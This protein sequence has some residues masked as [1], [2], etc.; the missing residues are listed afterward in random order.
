MLGQTSIEPHLEGFDE[1][2]R[3]NVGCRS[4]EN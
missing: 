4:S 1:G 3:V 2:L